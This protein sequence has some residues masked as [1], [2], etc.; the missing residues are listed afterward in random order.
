MTTIVVAGPAVPAVLVRRT[1]EWARPLGAEPTVVE[2]E[3]AAREAVAEA[4]GPVVVV[5]ADTPRLGA[6]HR[7][8]VQA[9]L[10]AGSDL[11]VAPTLDGAVYL[12]AMR[13]PRPEVVGPRFSEVLEIGAAAGLE[14]GMLRHER[15]LAR[16]EDVRAL[17]AD[18][19]LD[20]EVRESLV[21]G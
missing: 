18:P 7:D 11:V 3:A 1:V 6:A 12:V 21:L 13:E 14:G 5:W 4:G 20:P 2:S 9:D 10:Q 19:L 17:L 8:G 16:P 15:R